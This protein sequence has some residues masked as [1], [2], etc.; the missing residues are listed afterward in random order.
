MRRAA[1]K[2]VV[3]ILRQRKNTKFSFLVHGT[4]TAHFQLGT[5]VFDSTELRSLE[6]ICEEIPPCLFLR[7]LVDAIAVRMWR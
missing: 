4:Q 5:T 6:E 2:V 1:V 3:I 7:G